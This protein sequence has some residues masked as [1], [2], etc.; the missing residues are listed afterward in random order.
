MWWVEHAVAEQHLTVS[1]I[2]STRDREDLLTGAIRS[3]H[4]QWHHDWQ[5]VIVDDGSTDTTPR[6]LAAVT[7]PRVVIARTEGI[8]AAAARNV[9]LD[10]ATGDVIA[11]L[12]DDNRLHPGWL[13]TLAWVFSTT[14][15]GMAFGA[16]VVEQSESIHGCTA[17][18]F[19]GLH[20]PTYSRRHQRYANSID[21][22]A[23]AH[24]PR[25]DVRFD[26]DP[27]IR[28][29][30]DWEYIR[31]LALDDTPRGLPM[32]SCFY[33]T[34]AANRLTGGRTSANALIAARSMTQ[35][36]RSGADERARASRC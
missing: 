25:P 5:L 22:G 1:V 23:L 12:D 15:I 29:T 10:L 9:G 28:S 6:L 31:R 3:V 7:D 32:I 21:L 36:H 17:T 19:P 18:D 27:R 24:R 11:F 8:G 4:Q 16:R 35:R 13:K 33:A 30:D 26:P 14:D 34:G 2:M 20:F